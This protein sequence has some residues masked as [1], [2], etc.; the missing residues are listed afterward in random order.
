MFH[1]L[2]WSQKGQGDHASG[3][4]H[5]GPPEILVP[6]LQ[7]GAGKGMS[8]KLRWGWARHGTNI[9]SNH[10]AHKETRK[11]E[12]ERVQVGAGVGG[13]KLHQ[14]SPARDWQLVERWKGHLISGRAVI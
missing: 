3:R 10:S 11:E 12:E 13:E 4:S 9:Q 14:D 6:N 5:G 8:W 7:A 2:F 1:A